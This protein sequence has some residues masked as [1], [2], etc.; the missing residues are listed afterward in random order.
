MDT[1]KSSSMLQAINYIPF[2]D[3]YLGP[4]TTFSLVEDIPVDPQPPSVTNTTNS[5]ILNSTTTVTSTTTVAAP[6]KSSTLL[7]PTNILIG[8]GVVCLVI[9]LSNK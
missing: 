9:L 5:S 1:T 7:T 8:T 3:G 4:P 2:G 6:T